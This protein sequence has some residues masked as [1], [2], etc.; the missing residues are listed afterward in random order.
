MPAKGTPSSLE[1]LFKA[2]PM[3]EK[4]KDKRRI[5]S[6]YFDVSLVYLL[7]HNLKEA[8]YYNLKGGVNL[9]DPSSPTYDYMKAHFERNMVRYYLMVD[10]VDLA[11]PYLRGLEE[12]GRRLQT[13]VI[14]LPSLF[15]SGATYARL[16]M[17]ILPITIL[18]WRTI[19]WIRLISMAWFKQ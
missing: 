19:S 11:L 15:L 9:P 5:S 7:I 18:N 4:A 16:G 12:R 14:Y 17:R 10:S 13:P 2:I 6:L 3:A 8:F 1:F